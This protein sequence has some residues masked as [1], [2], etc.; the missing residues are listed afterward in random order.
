MVADKKN[1]TAYHVLRLSH[2]HRT[3]HISSY[4]ANVI[5]AFIL[6]GDR[7]S[8]GVLEDN[9]KQPWNYEPIVLYCMSPFNEN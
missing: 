1:D 3:M 5:E 7:L 8:G 2:P 9:T 4:L 6:F